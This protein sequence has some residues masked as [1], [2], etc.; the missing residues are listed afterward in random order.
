[1]EC[2]ICLETI[3]TEFFITGCGHAS[4]NKCASEWLDSKNT[5]PICRAQ[6]THSKV[7]IGEMPWINRLA[8]NLRVQHNCP[9]LN[10]ETV[11]F[12]IRNV[13][14]RAETIEQLIDDVT[15]Q[16]KSVAQYYRLTQEVERREAL[17]RAQSQ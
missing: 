4:H 15:E 1:M 10:L 16:L 8:R 6:A 5:C 7:L 11:I 9:H 13:M 2:P 12:I 17:F 14:S 3:T